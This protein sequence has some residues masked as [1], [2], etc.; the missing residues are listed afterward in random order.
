M[1]RKLH[2]NLAF[3]TS[4]P[5]R[6]SIKFISAYGLLVSLFAL[7]TITVSTT[8]AQAELVDLSNPEHKVLHT[9]YESNW[10]VKPDFQ[11]VSQRAS[12]YI[13]TTEMKFMLMVDQQGKISNIQVIKS[14]GNKYVDRQ[15]MRKISTG[16]LKPFTLKGKPIKVRTILPIKVTSPS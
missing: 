10:V 2:T 7:F 9:V 8:S 12:E 11:Q 16:R 14:S 6:T 1:I 13:K 15:F 4:S 5:F 3:N